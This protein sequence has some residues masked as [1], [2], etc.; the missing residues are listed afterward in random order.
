MDKL[1]DANTPVGSLSDIVDWFQKRKGLDRWW[2][3]TG[4]VPIPLTGVKPNG[5]AGR[6]FRRGLTVGGVAVP[7]VAYGLGATSD[8]DDARFSAFSK[9]L[10]YDEKRQKTKQDILRKYL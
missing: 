5:L 4:N 6:N 10:E 2:N 7:T 9:Y 8:D 1:K 3:S